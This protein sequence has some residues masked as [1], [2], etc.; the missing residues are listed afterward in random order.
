M[1]YPVMRLAAVAAVV[2]L[3]LSICL[4]QAPGRGSPQGS[5]T[6]PQ[7]DHHAT[8]FESC[9]KECSDCQRICDSCATHCAKMT[10]S[11]KPEHLK[12]LQTCRDCA[13]FCAAAAQI[14]SRQGPF[15]GLICRS[16]AEACAQ[17]GKACEQFPSDAHMKQCAEECRRCEKAC[18]EMVKHMGGGAEHK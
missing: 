11:G 16:C 17:C 3:G 2:L 14:V 8:M 4:A 6:P 13:T 1:R 7:H 12:T 5:T 9:A 15:A 18:R 10:A